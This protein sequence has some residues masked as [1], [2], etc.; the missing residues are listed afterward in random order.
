MSADITHLSNPFK[1][2]AVLTSLWMSN[3][4]PSQFPSPLCFVKKIKKMAPSTEKPRQ[5]MCRYRCRYTQ[6]Y[7]CFS[8]DHVDTLTTLTSNAAARAWQTRGICGSVA[9]RFDHILSIII[10]TLF[11]QLVS[12]EGRSCDNSVSYQRLLTTLLTSLSRPPKIKRREGNQ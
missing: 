10:H 6:S 7:F 1:S 9:G 3:L 8:S 5:F 11:V 4:F 12:R 2:E